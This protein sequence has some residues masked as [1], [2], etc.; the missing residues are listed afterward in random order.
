MAKAFEVW[1]R[2]RQRMGED[3]HCRFSK[4]CILAGQSLPSFAGPLRLA[5]PFEATPPAITVQ[6]PERGAGNAAKSGL[7]A[8]AK[9]A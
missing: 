4:P 7:C 6:V 2:T 3:R 1:Y 9:E 5:P 8:I